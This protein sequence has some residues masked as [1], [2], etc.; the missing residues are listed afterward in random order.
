M[1][2][3]GGSA[4]TVWAEE[5]GGVDW[6]EAGDEGSALPLA[7]A[8]GLAEV[9][10]GPGGEAEGVVDSENGAWAVAGPGNVEL[11]FLP[12]P[13][14]A[15]NDARTTIVMAPAVPATSRR[16]RRP[17][18]G[19][20]PTSHCHHCLSTPTQFDIGRLPGDSGSLDGMTPKTP[21]QPRRAS[22]KSSF[23]PP[24]TSECPNA[25]RDPGEIGVLKKD[26][27]GG[28]SRASAMP[29]RRRAGMSG[30]P[31]G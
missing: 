24:S 22:G 2:L 15:R 19:D 10:V 11:A 29:T 21:G 13:P 4:L 8:P 30:W 26:P 20:S 16:D 12:G 5:A 27:F 7:L 25:S 6:D 17:G 31:I 3:V 1:A 18:R 23:R 9:L 28:P 14:D